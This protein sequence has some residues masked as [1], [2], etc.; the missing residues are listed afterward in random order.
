MQS[1]A[2]PVSAVRYL[3]DLIISFSSSC[4]IPDYLFATAW[5]KP[6]VSL[7]AAEAAGRESLVVVNALPA[8]G[9]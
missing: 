9:P 7:L 3:A 8:A 5:R 6:C 1:K 2:K 4:R